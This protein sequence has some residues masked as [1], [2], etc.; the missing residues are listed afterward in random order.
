MCQ[1]PICFRI[2]DPERLGVRNCPF[3]IC[4]REINYIIPVQMLT[5]GVGSSIPSAILLCDKDN[6]CRAFDS[7]DQNLSA[8]YLAPPHQIHNERNHQ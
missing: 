8:K 4:N 7:L 1:I 3:L 2:I 6:Y 5:S